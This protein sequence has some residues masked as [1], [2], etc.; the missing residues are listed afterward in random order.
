MYSFYATVR[1]EGQIYEE[2]VTD[3]TKDDHDTTEKEEEEGEKE[4]DDETVDDDEYE[5]L[6]DNIADWLMKDG[7]AQTSVLM[8]SFAVYLLA[9]AF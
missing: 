3:E 8:A 9:I 4:S 1:V 2:E 5:S 6:L 7:A